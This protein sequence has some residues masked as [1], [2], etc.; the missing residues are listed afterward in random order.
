V[1]E[2][3]YGFVNERIA[4]MLKRGLQ[5][6]IPRLG[7]AALIIACGVDPTGAD[8]GDVEFSARVDVMESFPVQLVGRL[9]VENTGD[10][11]VTVV[12]PDGCVALLSAFDVNGGD[13][14]VWTQSVAC[15]AVLVPVDLEPGE[16][17]SFSTP[18]ASARDILGTDLPDGEYR[19]VVNL[20]PD[21]EA[22]EIE[23]GTVEL[24]IPR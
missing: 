16:R 24:A 14:P 17:R 13:R 9:S 11:R 4:L 21:G 15:I 3:L 12:F 22:V 8:G 10:E 1:S 23:V 6:L 20:R 5:A 19:I 7:I 2:V 18:I